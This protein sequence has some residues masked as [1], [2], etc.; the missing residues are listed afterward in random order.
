MC[1]SVEIAQHQPAYHVTEDH[2]RLAQTSITPVQ[3]TI[4]K[5]KQKLCSI[6][7]NCNWMQVEIY[8]ITDERVQYHVPGHIQIFP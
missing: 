2:I 6:S 7:L 4:Q 8:Y 3:G 1:T 5:T